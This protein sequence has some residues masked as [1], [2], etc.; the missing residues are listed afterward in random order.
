MFISIDG[1]SQ[2]KTI[3]SLKKVFLK[4][5]DSSTALNYFENAKYGIKR[6]DDEFENKITFYSNLSKPI[7]LTK[8]IIGGKIRYYLSLDT[9][10]STLNYGIKGVY[11]LFT[12]KSKWNRLNEK[13]DV[14]YDDGYAY[15]AFIELLPN[16]LKLFQTKTISKFRLYI[17]DEIIDFEDAENFMIQSNYIQ[18]MKK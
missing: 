1:M 10:G 17:Y 16:D 15:S 14:S 4:N 6:V 12:D 11:V 13:I 8:V 2:T 5:Y 18:L 7:S 9:K 3:D